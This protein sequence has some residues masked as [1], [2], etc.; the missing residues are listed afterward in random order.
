MERFKETASSEFEASHCHIKPIQDDNY[1]N[2]V[3]FNYH[4]G[5]KKKGDKKIFIEPID[6]IQSEDYEGKKCVYCQKGYENT[7]TYIL[8]CTDIKQLYTASGEVGKYISNHIPWDERVWNRK[9]L[10]MDTVIN[11]NGK[12]LLEWQ[13]YVW[14]IL[15]K[16]LHDRSQYWI[17]DEYGGT[18]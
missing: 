13:N 2:E 11:E 6:I 7:L 5:F 8:N 15:Q 16:P 17:M 9:P 1:W 18:G 10:K 14:S 4:R 12:N 3:F